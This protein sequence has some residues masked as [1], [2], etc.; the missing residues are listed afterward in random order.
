MDFVSAEGD[1]ESKTIHVHIGSDFSFNPPRIQVETVDFIVYHAPEDRDIRLCFSDETLFGTLSETIKADK[2]LKLKVY[3][4]GKVYSTLAFDTEHE[5]RGGAGNEGK[6][7]V[8][9]G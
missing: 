5:C 6:S 4:H 7:R 2:K 9:G 1:R 8:G 3:P